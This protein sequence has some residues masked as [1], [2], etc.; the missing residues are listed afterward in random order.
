MLHVGYIMEMRDLTYETASSLMDI[1]P[2]CRIHTSDTELRDFGTSMTNIGR[3]T[4]DI[5]GTLCTKEE[6]IAEANLD[7]NHAMRT[8]QQGKDYRQMRITEAAKTSYLYITNNHESLK[9]EITQH[10]NYLTAESHTITQGMRKEET[11]DRAHG[12][13]HQGSLRSQCHD[14]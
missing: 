2:T 12:T 9:Q 6:S 7:L 5:Y 8:L 14:L 4:T 10:K 1:E 13:N 3:K 11:M